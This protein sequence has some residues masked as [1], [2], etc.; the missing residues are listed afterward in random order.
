[1]EGQYHI[2]E[3]LKI[4][5]NAREDT[6]SGI[7]AFITY[8]LKDGTN[9]HKK[10]WDNWIEADIPVKDI[11]NEPTEGFVLNKR[12]GG[13]GRWSF[14]EREPKI[15]VYDPRGW[16][17]E[18]TIENMLDILAQCGSYPGKGLEGKFIYGFSGNRL[19]LINVNSEDYKNSIEFTDLSTMDVDEKDLIVGAT[20][21]TKSQKTL[22]YLGVH[23]WMNI[24]FYDSEA[25][26]EKAHLFFEA[27]RKGITAEDLGG[28]PGEEFDPKELEETQFD[29]DMDSFK[30][31]KISDLAKCLDPIPVH[32]LAHLIT[33]LEGTGKVFTKDMIQTTKKKVKFGL[34]YKEHRTN[35]GIFENEYGY[36]WDYDIYWIKRDDNLYESVKLKLVFPETKTHDYS[37]RYIA[38]GLQ[39]V[40][41]KKIVITD[42]GAE[43]KKSNKQDKKIYT[44]EQILDME[45]FDVKLNVS[46]FIDAESLNDAKKGW[47]R[48]P[49]DIKKYSTKEIR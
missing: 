30:S 5:F 38:N 2:P 14:N 24:S 35:S 47:R 12:E 28:L 19:S 20:Y 49:G 32:D 36:D 7:L 11:L 3:R 17:F 44:P 34:Y 33:R 41:Q 21:L 43:I 13:G 45:F 25:K 23:P 8:T 40:Y 46:K 27:S 37:S 39:I 31:W 4:G 15:R 29:I 16:E 22:V 18:I 26:V 9:K 48:T 10:N 42:D 1:M 6:Y